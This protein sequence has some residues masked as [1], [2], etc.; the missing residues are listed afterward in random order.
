ME[1]LVKYGKQSDGT[2]IY[3]NKITGKYHQL[4]YKRAGEET[5]SVAVM[6]YLKG[7]SYRQ[8]AQVIGVSH[9]TILRWV[10]DVA[11]EVVGR[12]LVDK[13]QV[14]DHVEIDEMWHFCKKKLKRNG[15]SSR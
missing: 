2:Q 12:D 15:F 10:K 3:K 5:K 7:M 13:N 6:M 4:E 14:Y 9:V 11:K 8:V 1:N